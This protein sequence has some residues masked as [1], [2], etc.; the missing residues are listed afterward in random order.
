MSW[1]YHLIERLDGEKG[2]RI[3]PYKTAQRIKMILL[4]FMVCFIM[5]MGLCPIYGRDLWKITAYCSCSKCCGKS[6]GITVSGHKAEQ[7]YVACNW[8]PFGTKVSIEG[9][10]TFRVM[11]RG[12][13]SLF[14]SKDNHIKHIDI[15]LPTHKEAGTFGVQY[16]EVRIL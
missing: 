3:M 16:K 8:L 13:R 1:L 6:D 12:A 10:G 14:G 15:W 2:W 4:S 9:L 5:G 11:D 7:G